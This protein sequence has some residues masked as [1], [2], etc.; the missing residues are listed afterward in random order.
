MVVLSLSRNLNLIWH[1]PAGLKALVIT[2]TRAHIGRPTKR[3]EL[4]LPRMFSFPPGLGSV[5]GSATT[6]THTTSRFAAQSFGCERISQLDPTFPF[7]S[8]RS[9]VLRCWR[10]E[11]AISTTKS[12]M[13]LPL[14]LFETNTW[15]RRTLFGG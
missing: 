10:R 6:N 3:I 13:D 9:L 14:P 4:F 8:L 11:V 15:H 2:V 1:G 12:F 7:C 5:S